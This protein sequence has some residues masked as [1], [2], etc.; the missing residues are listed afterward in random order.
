[1][2]AW[3]SPVRGAMHVTSFPCVSD[4]DRCSQ[5]DARNPIFFSSFFSSFFLVSICVLR[6]STA[7]TG[8]ERGTR[9]LGLIL[10]VGGGGMEWLG[11]VVVGGE[12]MRCG[13]VGGG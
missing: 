12:V 1:M 11:Q 2:H 9:D 8:R 7:D 5:S 4:A 10:T 3:H 6:R 13:V